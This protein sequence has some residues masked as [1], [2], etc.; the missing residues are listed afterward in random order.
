[1]NILEVTQGSAEWHAARAQH[2]CASEAPAMMAVS[3]YTTRSELLRQKATGIVPEVSAATQAL[4]DAGHADEDA[5]RPHAEEIIG[6][7]L[8]AVTG[9]LVVDSLALLASLDGINLDDTEIWENKHPN[10]DTA[11]HIE[12]FGEPPE[13]HIWQLEHQLLVSG[14]RR[15]LFTCGDA[16]CWYESDSRR[17]QQLIAGWKQFSLDLAAYVPP[18]PAAVE[19]IV[20]EPVEDFPTPSAQVTGEIAL[21]DNFN[22]FE[23]RLRLFLQERLIREP[24]TDQD[25]ADL[26]QQIKA[27]K[28][29]RESLKA[30]GAQILAQ[31][32]PIQQATNRQKMLD[33]LLQEN[34][35]MA[36]R[37]L[38]NEKERRKGEIVAGGVSAL[39]AHVDAL[40]ARLGK[41]YMPAV[42][43][44]FGGVVKGLKSLAS[45]EDKIASELARCKIAANEVAD[46][47]EINLK[48]L[49]AEAGEYGALFPDLATVVQKQP[50]DFTALVQFRVADHKAKE[51]KR[52]EALAEQ[53]R[54]RI[55]AEEEAR[56]RAQ[57]A[58]EQQEREEAERRQ[59][60]EA[61]ALQRQQV[62]AAAAPVHMAHPHG[63]AAAMAH[64]MFPDPQPTAAPVPAPTVIPMPARN[65]APTGK[66]TLSLGQLKERIAPLEI[67][68]DGMAALGFVGLKERG[69]VLYHE[70]DFPHMLAAIVAHVQAIQ[71]KQAA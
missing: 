15:A 38:S 5:R 9:T 47:I 50:D 26:D 14:A 35:S 59:R 42:P 67:K 43:A 51:Q 39:K 37:L 46:R 49:A 6:G 36:E 34:L 32:E 25:F 56:A 41:P 68:A 23:E 30:A 24:K 53:A 40:N 19:K 61:E 27:M 4:F 20:A 8:Y 54:E 16:H 60:E 10:K 48:H 45:M 66:P 3:P 29:A 28:L 44:D 22:V 2:F 62:Q 71:A 52:A 57:A 18:S 70:A 69:S 1:M 31:V 64:A 65:V 12:M 63:P 17:R 33:K 55:R 7:E 58:R 13:H 11:K 21:K